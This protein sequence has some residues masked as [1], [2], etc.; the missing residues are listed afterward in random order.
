MKKIILL[1]ILSAL[2]ISSFAAPFSQN[3]K[4]KYERGQTDKRDIQIDYVISQASEV[5][6]IVSSNKWLLDADKATVL[7]I[8]SNTV[9]PVSGLAKKYHEVCA[10]NNQS[11]YESFNYFIDQYLGNAMH[12]EDSITDSLRNVE[13]NQKDIK[14]KSNCKTKYQCNVALSNEFIKNFNLKVSGQQQQAAKNI[15]LI[16][17]LIQS[18]SN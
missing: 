13:V 8:L 17:A 6:K 12:I 15:Q 11:F 4:E 3:V 1:S 7:A 10:S 18:Q 2:S 9:T 16:N 14:A 5:N